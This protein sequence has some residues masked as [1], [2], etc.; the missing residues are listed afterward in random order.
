[1]IAV[2][3]AADAAAV[4]AHYDDLD[5]FYRS[6]WGNHIHH[7]CW[8]SGEETTA[9]AVLNLTRLI[10]RTAKIKPGHR[11]C[12]LGCG[13]GASALLFAREYQAAVVGLT[14]SRKQYVLA[15][16]AAAATPRVEFLLRD[17]LDNRLPGGS[18]DC[19][20]AIES[21]EHIE[22]KH[23]LFFEALR[24]LR[25]GGRLAV[26]AWLTREQPR[27][28]QCKYLLEP[29]CAE[30]RLPTLASANEFRDMIAEAGFIDITFDELTSRVQRTWRVC[31][32]RMARKAI[33]ESAFRRRLLDPNFSNRVFAKAVL[34]I[35][36]AYKT[37][38]MRYGIFSALKPPR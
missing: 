28:W 26:A 16:E 12:D 9:E 11:V 6:I 15:R 30:G 17:V 38:S 31:A 33:S 3:P 7:G 13:Y 8:I 2:S 24:L 21:S 36:L 14:I 10:A 29:I 1:M 25:P 35:W 37:A 20:V 22:D 4:A 5:E 19:V 34:R 32:L 23:R 18:F 27:A